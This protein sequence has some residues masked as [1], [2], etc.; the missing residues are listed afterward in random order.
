[1]SESLSPALFLTYKPYFDQPNATLSFSSGQ[2]GPGGGTDG[3]SGIQNTAEWF[4]LKA[5]KK[6]E[7]RTEV[8]WPVPGSGVPGRTLK[9]TFEGDS[10]MIRL[11]F[12]CGLCGL[13]P[14]L[15][16]TGVVLNSVKGSDATTIQLDRYDEAAHIQTVGEVLR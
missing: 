12:W 3:D 13:A 8:D 7:V 15:R 16:Y 2:A 5:Q 1:M 9:G 4:L 14:C 6:V 11:L 10:V